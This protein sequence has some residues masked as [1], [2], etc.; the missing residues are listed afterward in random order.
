LQKENGLEYD[1]TGKI[2]IFTRLITLTL[3]GILVSENLNT[4]GYIQ[5]LWLIICVGALA[6]FAIWIVKN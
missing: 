6:D 5:S 2:M 3:L 4:I 1:I